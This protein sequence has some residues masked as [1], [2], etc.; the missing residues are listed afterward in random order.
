MNAERERISVNA[1][2]AIL[3][4]R[5]GKSH[6][7]LK[8][9]LNESEIV[10]IFVLVYLRGGRWSLS[11]PFRPPSDPLSGHLLHIILISHRGPAC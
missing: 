1:Q 10:I 5:S 3:Q 8:G 11:R 7:F 9:A 2:I 4:G 6:H